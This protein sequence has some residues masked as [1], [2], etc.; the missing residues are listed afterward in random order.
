MGGHKK[1]YAPTGLGI[2]RSGYYF[3]LQWK[4]GEK[5]IDKQEC[6]IYLN[7]IGQNV[8]VAKGTEAASWPCYNLGYWATYAA[9]A[10]RNAD[11]ANKIDWSS[12]SVSP[13]LQLGPAHAPTL[14]E[15]P[16]LNSPTK[17]TFSW[18][19]PV[20]DTDAYPTTG[21]QWESVL[22]KDGVADWSNPQRGSANAFSGSQAF[23]E[24]GFGDGDYCYVRYF[25]IRG[26]GPIGA[27][28]W[29]TGKH[30]YAPP[31]QASITGTTYKELPNGG[32]QVTVSWK[33]EASEYRPI[34]NITVKYLAAAPRVILTESAE[35]IHMELVPPNTDSGWVSLK[36]IGGGKKND[37]KASS[38]MVPTVLDDD[39]CMFV[40][41]DNKHDEQLTYSAPVLVTG[42]VGRIKMPSFSGQIEPGGEG[43][44]RIYT[45]T[46]NRNS[47]A[48]EN[49]AIAI[50]FR[51]DKRPG[52]DEI[53]GVVPPKGSSSWLSDTI[54][55]II[56]VIQAGETPSFGL[57][58]FVGDYTP[59]GPTSLD[60]TTYYSIS[61][62]KMESDLNW[63]GGVVPLPPALSLTQINSETIQVVWTWT[64]RE[65]TKAEISWA[66]HE[67]AWY[68]TDEPQTYVV[69]SNNV[70]RWNITG[71]SLDKWYFRIRL[72][73]V[74]DNVTTYGTYSNRKDLTLSQS[75]NIPTLMLQPD[76]ISK[77]GSTRAIWAYESSD[78]T[79]QLYAEIREAFYQYARV[80]NLSGSPIE[81]G[82]YEENAVEYKLSTD[83]TVITGKTYYTLDG[84]DYVIVANPSGNPSEQEY[85]E[86][87]IL[88]YKRSFDTVVNSMKDYYKPTGEITYGDP[89]QST[90]TEQH[91]ILSAESFGWLPGETHNLALGLVSSAG[92]PTNSLSTPVPITI[93]E[94]ITATITEHSF[95]NVSETKVPEWTLTELPLTIKTTG[96]GVGGKTTYVIERDE[97]YIIRR[98]D[99]TDHYGFEG[100]TV[101]VK[102]QEGENT[103]TINLVD[104]IGALDD[105]A[106]YRIIATVV[107]SYGQTSSDTIHFRV[108]WSHQASI[109]EAIFSIDTEKDV[110]F[111]TPTVPDNYEQGDLCDIYRLSADAPELIFKG[112]EFGTMYV[113]PYPVFGDFGGYRVVYRTANGDYIAGATL[114]MSDYYA[115]DED[116]DIRHDK[117]GIVIDF[118]GEQITLPYNVT[119]SNSWKKDF[120]KTIYL[121]GSVQGDW[122]PAIERDTSATTVIPVEVEPNQIE[123]LRRL[124]NFAGVCH[125]RTP[126]GSS[127]NA[128][129]QVRDDR[130]EKWVSRLSRVSLT[131]ARVDATGFEGMTYDDWIN[132]QTPDEGN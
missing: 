30:V 21:Y 91:M 97:T 109:P 128:D 45:M 117:F 51:T 52:M 120:Q 12:W 41:V 118:D 103:A 83:I 87:T 122:N 23:E 106:K 95:V 34:D 53:I 49:A 19:V 32:A 74:S 71:L 76:V 81:N 69:G 104:L 3:Y 18:N 43:A 20:S 60:D 113:D 6:V 64:W 98:P 54:Q 33:S 31:L 80:T 25:R 124:A 100:E 94:E 101:I 121:G 38:F 10:V 130:E 82:Y 65:A 15:E 50:H 132:S 70:S 22:A 39:Q 88:T 56:P 123:S 17:C 8:P 105:G 35:S 63:T 119:L 59:I 90:N 46:I 28:G 112:A 16:E 84:E 7:G 99:D 127:F 129:I 111:I 2:S 14:P 47:S 125:I 58:A 72:M 110:T 9:F 62:I 61:N 1:T 68:S 40:R 44:E 67:D 11:T 79:S 108:D 57:S 86:K 73:K 77:T 126:D 102:E 24:S 115:D 29:V 13:T 27:S 107:D 48:I 78:G 92:V 55:V 85:Y 75:P 66:N 26:L 89:I 116:I 114:A 93:A 36:E 131:V 96:A 42:G 37:S 5:G 4:R